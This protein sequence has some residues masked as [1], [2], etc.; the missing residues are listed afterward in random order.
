MFDLTNYKD[1]LAERTQAVINL[2]IDD[3]KK[4]QQFYVGVEHLFIAFITIEKEFYNDLT[5]ALGIERKLIEDLLKEHLNN[6]KYFVT[7]GVKFLPDANTVMQ[8]ALENIRREGKQV[9]MPVDLLVA[10][11]EEGH[12]YP[13]QLLRGFGY[14]PRTVIV[15]IERLVRKRDEKEKELKK[16]YELPP[17]LKQFGTNLNKLA[18]LDKLPPLIGREKELGQ[19]MEILSHR[20]RS[21]SVM[22]VGE[23]GVGKTAIVEGLARMIE[24]EPDRV[25]HRLEDKQIVNLQMNTIVA[26]TMFRGM[27][28]DRI[29]R[30]I[31]ELKE[32][33]NIILFVDEAHSLVGAGSAMGVPSDAANIFKS[34][35]ARGEVQIIGATTYTEYK[36]FIAEDEAL[37]R[38]FRLVHVKEPSFAEAKTIL[39]GV[40]PRLEKL[41]SVT[42]PQEA[43]DVAVEMS[44]RYNKSVRLPDKVIGWLDTSSV[45]TE[46]KNEEV[47]TVDTVKEVVAQESQIP[48]DMVSRDTVQ[49]FL[50]I[51][52]ILSRRVMGQHEAIKSVTDYIRLNKGPL[53]ENYNRPDAVLLFL[54]PTGVGK[55][56][57][58]KAL[59]EFFY[60]DEHKIVRIDMSEYSDS[61]IAVDKL[62]GMPRG[63]VG[64]ERGGILTNMVKDNP[65]SVVLLD[66]IEKANSFIHNLL[67]QVF[68]EGWLTDGRGKKIYF[69]DTIIIMTSNLGADQFKKF[70]QPLGFLKDSREGL[71]PLRKSVMAEAE[72]IFSPEFLNRIDEVIV[73]NPLEYETVKDIARKYID[74]IMKQTERQDRYLTV[75]ED[76]LD[77]IVANGYSQKYGARLLKRT[78]DQ[79]IKIPLTS[80]WDRAKKFDIYMN[81]GALDVKVGFEDVS[82]DATLASVVT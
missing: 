13:V 34:S 29:E 64:S 12:C 20:E 24:L 54:G 16:K 46:I 19:I 63:I 42:I 31:K 6:S 2:A 80:N 36:E 18:R 68:D 4:R 65:S 52:D 8:I 57:L 62:I 59:A 33:Q 17:Y 3:S 72:R 44:Q 32:R 38:R 43:V 74:Q 7:R 47:V 23:A 27:F 15:E 82:P 49:R 9:I 28:E 55:T 51:E 26:G 77:Y 41:Y 75:T 11:F 79:L 35:L 69:S 40:I 25:P 53:K 10:M 14:D 30:I 22:L 1:R 66:E 76:A 61:S 50:H 48:L 60:E 37:A 78:I 58:A 67:L 21:N 70:M 39:E 73:F 81:N 5:N 71:G 45:K 56:E